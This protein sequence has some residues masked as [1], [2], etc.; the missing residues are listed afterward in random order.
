MTIRKQVAELA[1]K[2]LRSRDVPYKTYHLRAEEIPGLTEGFEV[3]VT[4]RVVEPVAENW[5]PVWLVHN[6]GVPA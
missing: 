1:Q 4:I 5:T 3:Q 6:A 2:W